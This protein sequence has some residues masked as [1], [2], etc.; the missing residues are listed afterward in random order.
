M[1]AFTL[2][3][4]LPMNVCQKRQD[5]WAEYEVVGGS[6]AAG[7]AAGPQC[8]GAACRQPTWRRA[9]ARST[10]PAAGRRVVRMA[11]QTRRVRARAPPCPA[12]FKVHTS[13]FPD[14]L[15][16]H[17]RLAATAITNIHPARARV[18]DAAALLST[19]ALKC[20]PRRQIGQSYGPL[21]ARQSPWQSLNHYEKLQKICAK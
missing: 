13:T 15:R 7:W 8:A 12:S 3:E 16:T 4:L 14:V 6:G 18:L 20:R 9:A 19:R 10:Q 17:A 11:A 2:P 5:D 21:P 1:F